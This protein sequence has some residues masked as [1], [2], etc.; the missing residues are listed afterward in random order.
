M[1]AGGGVAAMLSASDWSGATKNE[2]DSTDV[3]GMS[4]SMC[5]VAPKLIPS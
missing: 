4:V 1:G 3:G 5:T 2:P